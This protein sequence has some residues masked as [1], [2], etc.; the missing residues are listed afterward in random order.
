MWHDDSGNIILC[1]VAEE[2]V[3]SRQNPSERTWRSTKDFQ[4]Y[5]FDPVI[6]SCGPVRKNKSSG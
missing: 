4:V 6:E 2:I 3:I 1:M 5:M